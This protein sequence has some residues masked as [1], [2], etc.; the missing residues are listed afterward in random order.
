MRAGPLWAA[1]LVLGALAGVGVGVFVFVFYLVAPCGS[2]S[3]DEGP[4]SHSVIGRQRCLR[5]WDRLSIRKI[6]SV[7]KQLRQGSLERA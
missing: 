3:E 6:S 7:C 5:F 2:D 4:A 1:V